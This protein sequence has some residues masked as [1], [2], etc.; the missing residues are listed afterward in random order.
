MNT[1]H[2]GREL[3]KNIRDEVLVLIILSLD[4]SMF[5]IFSA[6]FS[7]QIGEGESRLSRLGSKFCI[8]KEPLA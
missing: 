2:K 5:Q 6:E 3:S 7:S 4:L 8:C 1:K